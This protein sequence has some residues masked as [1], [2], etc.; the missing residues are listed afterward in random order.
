MKL[1]LF[2]SFYLTSHILH[3]QEI[4]KQETLKFVNEFISAVESHN[5]D[6][7][8]KKL[9]KSFV[10][11]QLKKF[12]K[13]NKQQFLD[14]LFTGEEVNS[15]EFDAIPFASIIS[16]KVITI[17]ENDETMTDYYFKIKTENGEYICQLFLKHISKGKKFKL[18]FEGSFG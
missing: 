17:E 8:I 13:G 15:K 11:V 5:E 2:I 14:E 18:G 1:L 7:V 10:K 3:A 12:L 6:L 4:S 16:I 9:D